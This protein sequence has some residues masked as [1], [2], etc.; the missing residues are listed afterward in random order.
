MSYIINQSFFVR[1]IVVP[2]SN[3]PPVLE[4]LNLFIAKYEKEC[5]LKILGYPLY[6]VFGTESSQRM[7]DLLHGAEYTDLNGDLQ[8]YEGLVH[9]END[10]LIANYIYYYFQQNSA[11][12]STGISTVKMSAEAGT[13][14]SPEEKMIFA[15]NY[16]SSEVQSMCYFL[17][18]KREDYPEFTAHQLSRT[19]DLSRPINPFDL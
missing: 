15:W 8:L 19:L 17:W 11:T 2:N 16:F 4:R 13:S 18:S 10:S 7:T 6:K 3:T 12:L 1:D 9:D 14:V 5:L